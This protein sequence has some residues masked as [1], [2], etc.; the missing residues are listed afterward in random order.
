MTLP[1]M[2]SFPLNYFTGILSPRLLLE[3]KEPE[4]QMEKTAL[5][6]ENR[7]I[8]SVGSALCRGSSL[9]VRNSKR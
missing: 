9:G 1:L 4:D 2:S 6:Q 5:V 8:L 3:Q 7:D